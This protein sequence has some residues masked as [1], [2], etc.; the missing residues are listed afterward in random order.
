M[1]FEF[2]IA[3]R[4]LDQIDI[5][6]ALYEALSTVLENNLNEFEQDQVE[7][8]VQIRCWRDCDEPEGE[9][10]EKSRLVLIDFCLEL[11]DETASVD[12]VVEELTEALSVTPPI[13]H[14]LRFEDAIL[15]AQ[16]AQRAAEI[17]ALEMKLR[18]VLSLIYLNA[19]Q[20]GDPYDLLRDEA[21]K[22]F[23]S[24]DQPTL[25]H[26]QTSAENQFFHLTFSQYVNLNQRSDIKLPAM[27]EVVRAAEQYEAFRREILR[28]PVEDEDDAVLLAGLKDRMDAIERMRNCVA[29][30]RRPTKSISENY[31]NALPLLNRM[32]DEYLARWQLRPNPAS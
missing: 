30:N 3:C 26:M 31:L 29:H 15:Q 24:K 13:F 14:V 7:Q 18:R 32:L 23:N 4:I 28:V 12:I 27:L 25:Q 9:G 2:F 8:M 17:Y 10:T 5:R 19:Y 16:F 22:P 21:V 6:K 1:T 20:A 11:P